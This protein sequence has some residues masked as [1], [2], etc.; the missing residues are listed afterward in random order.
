MLKYAILV[1]L[2]LVLFPKEAFVSGVV[3]EKGDIDN[4]CI[5]VGVGLRVTRGSP[6]DIERAH[7]S[8]E[9]RIAQCRKKAEEIALRINK[10]WA[11]LIK[12]YGLEKSLG[13]MPKDYLRV[14]VSTVGYGVFPV[15]IDEDIAATHDFT[16]KECVY[17][18]SLKVDNDDVE[19]CLYFKALPAKDIRGII[20]NTIKRGAKK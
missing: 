13:E 5:F 2:I 1:L 11:P 8:N 12:R 10:A 19:V 15:K 16:G 3:F 18:F 14:Q 20:V 6:E 4:G 7:K 17:S 9:E